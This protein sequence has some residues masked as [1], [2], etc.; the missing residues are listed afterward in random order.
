M[1]RYQDY[2][3]Q[4]AFPGGLNVYRGNPG[5][6]RTLAEDLERIGVPIAAADVRRSY[7]QI[8]S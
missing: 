7:T 3:T 6:L 8:S 2:Q 5:V 4:L 1:S